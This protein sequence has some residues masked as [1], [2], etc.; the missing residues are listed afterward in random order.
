MIDDKRSVF[1]PRV[2]GEICM[3]ERRS[4]T[5]RIAWGLV[6]HAANI[7][8]PERSEWSQAMISEVDHLPAL[9]LPLHGQLVAY[10]PDISK[11][12]AP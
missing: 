12:C 6:S 8:P 7:L 10:T 2:I 9:A 3:T 4:I 5:W 1:L 11:G